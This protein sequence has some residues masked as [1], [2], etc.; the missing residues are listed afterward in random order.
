M[1]ATTTL[2][3]TML[4]GFLG[5]GCGSTTSPNT[6]RGA[7]GGAATGAVLG[8]VIGHQ[9][10]EAPAGAAIGA[11]AGG[12]A[13]AALGNA[14]DRREENAAAAA[15]A[16][17][18]DRQIGHVVQTPPPAPTSAPYENVPPRPSA[19]AIWI[20]G[21]YDYTGQGDQYRWVSGR[22][23][24]PPPGYRS[25]VPP[26]WEQTSGGYVYRRGHWQ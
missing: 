6:Q 20:P 23:E 25:W 5:A 24:V 14:A 1:N 17:S 3:A 10:G 15:A 7:I 19:E 21:Y 11:A 16:T 22:W 4:I 9:S 13:G 8:G 26:S 18:A 12:L 2:I